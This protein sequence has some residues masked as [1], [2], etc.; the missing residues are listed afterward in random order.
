[1]IKY[2]RVLDTKEGKVSAISMMRLLQNFEEEDVI[3]GLKMSKNRVN[4]NFA[5]LSTLITI[6]EAAKAE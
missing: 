6:I 5:T 2:A 3:K 4:N 1:F